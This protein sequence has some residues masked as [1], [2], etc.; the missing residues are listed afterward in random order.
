MME[1]YYIMKMGTGKTCSAL[2]PVE[3][4]IKDKNSPYNNVLILAKGDIIIN[5]IY[6]ELGKVC[7]DGIYIDDDKKVTIDEDEDE[8]KKRGDSEVKSVKKNTKG[9]YRSETFYKIC[10]T[11]KNAFW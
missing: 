4:I 8:D 6:R 5:N 1:Y 9:V 3:K 11:K 7:T 10:F 2:G